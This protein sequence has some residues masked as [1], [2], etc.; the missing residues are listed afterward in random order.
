M[1]RIFLALLSLTIHSSEVNWIKFHEE[2]GVSLYR[3]PEK[4]NG[5]IPFKAEATF[6]GTKEDYLKILLSFSQKNQWAPKLK[7][8]KV[9]RRPAPNQFIF[10]EYYETP[11]PATDREFLLR[12]RI[13]FPSEKVI[14]LKAENERDLSYAK[15]DHIICD[16][17]ILNLELR[18]VGES[19]TKITFEFYGDMKGWMPIWLINL[20]QKRWPLRFLLSLEEIRSLGQVKLSEDYLMLEM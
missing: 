1:V 8:A 7:K 19:Q 17:K 4:K 2:D 6:R 15:A 3:A 16:V 5:L 12:G 11:W 18:E 10:S 13:D 20:I 14:L 9:H